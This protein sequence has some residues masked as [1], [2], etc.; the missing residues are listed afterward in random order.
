MLV[1]G[2]H[3]ICWKNLSL[4]IIQTA[5]ILF[6]RIQKLT[7]LVCRWLLSKWYRY[8]ELVTR[9]KR[10][11]E[12]ANE[13]TR[14]ST[15]RIRIWM[16]ECGNQYY[17]AT[18]IQNNERQQN[19]EDYRYEHHATFGILYLYVGKTD[20]TFLWRRP[21]RNDVAIA[22]S[23][24]KVSVT[25]SLSKTKEQFVIKM[26]YNNNYGSNNTNGMVPLIR[27]TH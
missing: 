1:N 5:Q 10:T 12:I 23:C 2:S 6:S 19:E 4:P 17:G 21:N 9:R 27:I 7:L 14:N 3:K 20:N 11:R 22:E 15:I 16:T 8:F 24:L 18:A 25:F 26:R 13:L